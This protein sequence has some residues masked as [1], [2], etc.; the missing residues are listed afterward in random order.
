MG[1]LDGVLFLCAFSTVASI[2]GP[3]IAQQKKNFGAGGL[4]L[5]LG[6]GV[7][8]R[9]SHTSGVQGRDLVDTAFGSL[10]KTL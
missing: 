7:A 10:A 9:G 1:V 5:Q 3:S 2:L 4:L 6:N 8:D